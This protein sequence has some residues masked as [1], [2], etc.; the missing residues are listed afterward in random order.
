[1]ELDL[2]RFEECVLAIARSSAFPRGGMRPGNY[3]YDALR[4]TF[5]S[6]EEV[7]DF[8][9]NLKR[10]ALD[11]L[12]FITWWTA[13]FSRWD[14]VLPQSVVSAI[15]DLD[16]GQYQKRGVLINLERD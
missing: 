4:E 13:S 15:C 2:R 8:G 9:A 5:T 1:M 11:Y 7:E 16:L 6:E 12:A 10:Q 14:T 3:Q